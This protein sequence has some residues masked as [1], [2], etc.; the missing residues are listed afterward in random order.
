MGAQPLDDAGAE[1]LEAARA[2]RRR[3]SP[4]GSRRGGSPETSAIEPSYS[5]VTR[6]AAWPG[7]EVRS[8]AAS[9]TAPR[10]RSQPRRSA[11]LLTSAASSGPERSSSI[12]P[13]RRSLPRLLAGVGDR[14]LGE[15]GQ[16]RLAQDLVAVE[17]RH[18]LDGVAVPVLAGE[19]EDD[20]DLLAG[21][22]HRLRGDQPPPAASVSSVTLASRSRPGRR[23]RSTRALRLPPGL[24]R[25]GPPRSSWS[26]DL[27]WRVRPQ[28]RQR[29]RAIP[30]RETRLREAARP[31]D[32]SR[33]PRPGSPLRRGT[34]AR[35]SPSSPV[36][37]RIASST[38]RTK[39]LPSPTSPV[40]AC[41]RIVSTTI[42]FSLSST[43]HSIF[44]F[45]RTLTVRVEPRY[46]STTPFCRPDPLTS[47]IERDGNS[48]VEQ[49]GPDRL[50]C[51]VADECF[52]LLHF[53][54]PLRPS[55][56]R[57]RL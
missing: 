26:R 4:A 14:Q 18:R 45:G 55:R 17:R 11:R 7:L 44:N 38:G 19:E 50:E 43:T 21:D 9:T 25:R 49:L 47:L 15:R 42:P 22:H 56:R 20:A 23:L 27:A 28:Q 40:R 29:G 54:H 33:P 1:Q 5:E 13:P 30:R 31:R 2:P 8:S 41:L 39:I 51:L 36:R 46:V 53:T 34:A 35:S 12:R 16:R 3:R 48:L 52:D 57:L 24:P 32:A 37:M 10:T 6:A